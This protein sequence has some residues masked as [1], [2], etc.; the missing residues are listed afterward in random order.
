MALPSAVASVTVYN[1]RAAVTRIG[2]V[3]L[4]P[5]N[6]L[7]VFNDLPASIVDQSARVSGQAAGAQILD[8]HVETSFLDTIP[9]DQLHAL[10]I[11][12]SGAAN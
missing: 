8:V 10:G 12:S 7:L 4:Q 9:E 11:E 3:S 6:Y 5:G 2:Q 1:D